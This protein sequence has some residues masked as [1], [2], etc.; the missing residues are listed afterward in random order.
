MLPQPPALVVE[1]AA[2]RDGHRAA[3][4][5]G[6]QHRRHPGAVPGAAR[7]GAGLLCRLQP[8]VGEGVPVHRGH[9]LLRGRR[10]GARLHGLRVPGAL[11]ARR[12]AAL[13]GGRRPLPV[14][15]ARRPGRPEPQL[16]R[17]V[18]VGQPDRLRP[19]LHLRQ[20]RA[21]LHHQVLLPQRHQ[22]GGLHVDEQE[23]DLAAPQ[24]DAA[25]RGR[26]HR[27][28]PLRV[29]R[30]RDRRLQRGSVLRD[31]Q[32]VH[33]L[34]QLGPDHHVRRRGAVCG[35]H[36]AAAAA[37]LLPAGAAGHGPLH[38]LLWRGAAR[39]VGAG[40]A[41]A[42]PG[43]GAVGA[44]RA[45]GGLRRRR[46]AVQPAAGR[47]HARGARGRQ[48]VGPLRRA[49]GAAHDVA[50][51]AA[52][53]G[54]GVAP[55]GR[56]HAAAAGGPAELDRAAVAGALAGGRLDAAGG[57]ALAPRA[58]A[59]ALRVPRVH[60]APGAPPADA[61]AARLHA[62]Q[63]PG[64]GRL[65]G[66]R[67]AGGEPAAAPLRL[68]VGRDRRRGAVLPVRVAAA[69]VPDVR[70]GRCRVRPPR[71]EPVPAGAVQRHRARVP[72]LGRGRRGGLPGV[73]RGRR[74]VHRDGPLRPVGPV[75]RGLRG[76]RVRRGGAVGA[77]PL[78]QPHDLGGHPAAERGARRVEAPQLRERQRHVP[79]HA[80]PRAEGA[81]GARL[82][83]ARVPDGR[84]AAG[85]PARGRARRRGAGAPPLP[86]GAAAAR[87][88][89]RGRLHALP[90]GGRA[91]PRAG[92]RLRRRVRGRGGAPAPVG[93]AVP[94]ADQPA[95][96]VRLPGHLL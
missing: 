69:R 32:L 72:P 23:R 29:P 15:R 60:R 5:R 64:G 81:P 21:P 76:R 35:H 75:P 71:G 67:A 70:A 57:A 90:G 95:L 93:A 2:P 17:G 25:A 59:R 22:A 28:E 7:Q 43:A 62:R 65:C 12:L 36:P 47:R 79:R 11:H 51:A 37:G 82:P 73:G 38:R 85:R 48:P 78:P 55:R 56:L 1:R 91:R 50:P 53:P 77:V 94:R 83:A 19:A 4:E 44:R 80:A 30:R 31:A 63:R 34:P 18:H 13:R 20:P 41:A 89:R 86:R 58:P 8:V 26:L 33:P 52:V 96:R 39:A 27:H 87:V 88:P 6:P 16:Q 74:A 54:R 45:A 92:V 46:R 66:A 61:G 40:G 3:R 10:P 24:P 42:G 68:P 49:G 84:A 14:L 9:L